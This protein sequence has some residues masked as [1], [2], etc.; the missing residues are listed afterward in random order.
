MRKSYNASCHVQK[1]Q[2]RQ[3]QSRPPELSQQ[4]EHTSVVLVTSCKKHRS[5][6]RNE[7]LQGYQGSHWARWR[8][9]PSERE[10]EVL[11][12]LPDQKRDP[13]VFHWGI[14][15]PRMERE[16]RQTKFDTTLKKPWVA[17]AKSLHQQ[18]PPAA[19]RTISK[20]NGPGTSPCH[21]HVARYVRWPSC[22]ISPSSSLLSRKMET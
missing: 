11:D 22:T 16:G 13:F 6:S 7:D 17:S 10:G 19:N 15:S 9:T 21:T 3:P 14:L 5:C 12:H 20:L 2:L 8:D 4:V 1:W 18:R